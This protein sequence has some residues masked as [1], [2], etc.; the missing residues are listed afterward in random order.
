MRNVFFV[1]LFIFSKTIFAQTFYL[2]GNT[3]L[4]IYTYRQSSNNS[5]PDIPIGLCAQYVNKNSCV[6][7]ELN[8]I[9]QPFSPLIAD[10]NV[11]TP[12]LATVGYLFYNPNYRKKSLMVQLKAG[13][14][15]SYYIEGGYYPPL[16]DYGPVLG[17]NFVFKI[18]KSAYFGFDISYMY[19]LKYTLVA[20]AQEPNNW[21]YSNITYKNFVL[22][23]IQKI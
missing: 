12:A 7:G 6:G 4:A 20:D 10:D 13:F 18:S 22:K 8:I 3:G 5:Y 1:V 23:F 9:L 14:F 19:G 11:A 15:Y 17:I 21:N 16:Y 2:G